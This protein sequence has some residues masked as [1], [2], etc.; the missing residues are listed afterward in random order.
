MRAAVPGSFDASERRLDSSGRVFV[1][2]DLAGL[3]SC[4]DSVSAGEILRPDPRGETI[5][6]VVGD[7]DCFLLV[8]EGDD[9][10]NRPKDLFPCNPRRIVDT[11]IDRRRHVPTALE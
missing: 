3:K 11:G 5:F 8:I 6:G 4:C 1:D 9:Y 7:A 2:V 10:E